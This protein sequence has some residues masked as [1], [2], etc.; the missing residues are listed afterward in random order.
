MPSELLSMRPSELTF[1]LSLVEPAIKRYPPADVVRG[2]ESL[3]VARESRAIDGVLAAL[4]VSELGQ[5]GTLWFR[6]G[7]A[8][9]GKILSLGALQLGQL[10]G[11]G[12]SRLDQMTE[13]A[14]A[15]RGALPQGERAS[16]AVPVEVR[17][18]PQMGAHA[19]H[20]HPGEHHPP[21]DAIAIAPPR[22][23]HQPPWFYRS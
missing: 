22:A 13:A 8:T 1:R 20:A 12:S 3:R 16:A 14:R 15:T 23:G 5:G 10:L 18:G 4:G 6:T 9:P 17:G 7:H 21:A 2:F 19:H 11:G